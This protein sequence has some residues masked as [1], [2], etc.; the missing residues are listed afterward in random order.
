MKEEKIKKNKNKKLQTE[1]KIVK[2]TAKR[3]LIRDQ[4]CCSKYQTSGRERSVEIYCVC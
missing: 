3:M 4:T 2:A 1:Q